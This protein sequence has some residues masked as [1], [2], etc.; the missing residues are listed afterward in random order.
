MTP[1]SASCLV[2][3]Q[4][5][6]NQNRPQSCTIP[7][8]AAPSQLATWYNYKPTRCGSVAGLRDRALTTDRLTRGTHFGVRD[9]EG[10]AGPAAQ[11]GESY[12]WALVYLSAR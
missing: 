9:C 6:S 4:S 8:R 2:P 7:L 12:V 11:V 10:G 3:S 5:Y 1:A